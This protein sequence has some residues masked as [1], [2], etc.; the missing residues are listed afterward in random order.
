MAQLLLLLIS[1]AAIPVC[2]YAETTTRDPDSYADFC[3]NY[4]LE[5]AMAAVYA[6]Y[7]IP[8]G[9]TVYGAMSYF[10][11]Y[12]D[13]AQFRSDVIAVLRYHQMQMPPPRRS[14]GPSRNRR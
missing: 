3:R 5:S 8:E 14:S 6:R 12:E 7:G 1:L 4:G 13:W 9:T 2:S 10:A 11:Y